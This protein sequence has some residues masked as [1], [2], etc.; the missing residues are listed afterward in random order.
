MAFR[1]KLNKTIN[2]FQQPTF[3]KEIQR[4]RSVP[5][6]LCTTILCATVK[7]LDFPGSWTPDNGKVLKTVL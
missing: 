7:T 4:W 3:D 2:S 1:L 5:V 6:R